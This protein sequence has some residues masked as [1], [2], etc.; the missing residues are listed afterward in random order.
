[1]FKATSLNG[2]SLLLK[3]AIGFITSKFIAL[4]VGPAGMALVGNLRNFLTAVESVGSLGFEN[5]VVKYTAEN[6]SVK[7]KLNQTLATVFLSVLVSCLVI[8]LGLLLF[9]D[10]LNNLIFGS[11]YAFSFVFKV[12]ALALPFYIGNIIF[13]AVINGLDDYKKVI[14]LNIIGSC[15]GLL[16]SVVFISQWQVA[17]ALLSIIVTPAILFVFSFFVLNREIGVLCNLKARYFDLS[18]LKNLS[19]Y[20]LMALVAALVGPLVFLAIRKH[21][22]ANIG[23]EQAGYWEAISRISSYYFLFITSIITIYFLPKMARSRKDSETKTLFWKYF[24]GIMPVFIFGIMAIYFLRDWIIRLLFTKEFLPVSELFF[25]QLAGDV[26]KAASFILAFE[27]YAKKMTKAFI[28]SELFSL[29]VLYFSS[30]FFL[31]NYGIQGVV[32]GHAFTYFVYLL[33]LC[34]FFRKKLY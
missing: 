31:E 18:V 34:V 4:F 23:M 20:S 22:I 14:R 19:A 9:S 17:G 2:V 8:M 25:W 32:M 5:G 11:G 26:F 12:L 24:K 28:F 33:V 6:Q 10:A 7:A 27:F 29:S 15:V 30:L 3:I 21:I 16:V 1:M 13:L